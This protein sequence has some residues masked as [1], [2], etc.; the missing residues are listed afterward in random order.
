MLLESKGCFSVS[1]G[2]FGLLPHACLPEHESRNHLGLHLFLNRETRS[3]REPQ[4]RAACVFSAAE[5]TKEA[6]SMWLYKSCN[7]LFY[8]HA[9]LLT[10]PLDL[11]NALA[12]AG[13]WAPFKKPPSDTLCSPFSANLSLVCRPSSLPPSPSTPQEDRGPVLFSALVPCQR[14]VTRGPGAGPLQYPAPNPLTLVTSLPRRVFKLTVAKKGTGDRSSSTTRP[15]RLKVLASTIPIH[16]ARGPSSR[17]S[18]VLW[19]HA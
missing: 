18:S 5:P 8:L 16:P 6:S 13:D 2:S 1:G 3:G 14:S 17:S 11:F 15:P 19:C 4:N 10:W 7:A 12:T 9:Y